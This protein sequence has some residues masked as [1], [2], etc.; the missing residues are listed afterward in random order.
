[1]SLKNVEEMIDF[2]E[3]ENVFYF[4]DLVDYARKNKKEWFRQLTKTETTRFMA[5]YIADRAYKAGK[6]NKEI[7]DEALEDLNADD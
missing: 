2:C 3:K 6:I 1:M 4:C 5:F 7:Y